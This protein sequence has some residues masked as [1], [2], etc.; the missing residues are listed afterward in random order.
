MPL[1]SG[2][3]EGAFKRNVSTLM[4]EIGKSPHVQSRA[5]ALAIA[6]SK[7]R[8]HAEGGLVNFQKGGEVNP[9]PERL[10]L[11]RSLYKKLEGYPEVQSA[12]RHVPRLLGIGP[13]ANIIGMAEDVARHYTGDLLFPMERLQ[14]HRLNQQ[15]PMIPFPVKDIPAPLEGGTSA[16]P[17]FTRPAF[18]NGGSLA[19][20][21]LGKL[22]KDDAAVLIPLGDKVA[23]TSKLPERPSGSV[24]PMQDPS[25][26]A[27]RQRLQGYPPL[28]PLPIMPY[29]QRLRSQGGYAT[30]GLGRLGV[31]HLG[32]PQMGAMGRLAGFGTGLIAK[33]LGMGF[34]KRAEGG[35]AEDENRPAT[36]NT[37][38]DDCVH[39]VQS[40]VPGRTDR[41]PMTA[42]AGSYILP[43][44]VVSGL[45][46][47]NTTAGAKMWADVL[48]L[49]MTQPKEVQ[50]GGPGG[51]IKM[52]PVPF[53]AGGADDPAVANEDTEIVVAGGEVVVSPECV[54]AI[55]G[56]DPE[57][58]K[59]ILNKSVLAVRE[60]VNAHNA[61]LPG[62]VQ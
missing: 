18:A 8:G 51:S 62:P 32:A 42:R 27:L 45:G 14:R 46:Q 61:T 30:G 33:G 55:G 40:A 13:R 39:L 41:I 15:M 31:S 23:D 58:G 43:A 25:A 56:G 21:G 47:G 54:A 26:E 9:I 52:P 1:E 3:S 7:K 34:K 12:L 5:Q 59:V 37:L 17:E 20:G 24:I 35:E 16:G 11:M 49:H 29:G 6:Y 53:A 36:G 57:K 38:D 4:G 22:S 2:S 19:R 50:G 48:K 10:P 44:D 60:Q 28:T